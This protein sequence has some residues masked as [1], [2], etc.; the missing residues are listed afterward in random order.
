MCPAILIYGDTER[1]PTLRHEVPLAIGD[2][3][4]FIQED[5]PPTIMTNSL[6][7]SRIERALPGARL[8]LMEE[9]G[10]RDLIKDGMPREDATLEVISRAVDRAGITAASVP[11]EFP[12]AVADRLRA[13]GVEL[14]VDA[15]LFQ[16]RRRVKSEPELAGIRR[17]QR[18]ANAAMAAAETLL[19]SAD[20]VDGRLVVDGQPLTAEMVRAEIRETC[21]EYGAPAPPDVMVT[22]VLSGGGHDPGS[23]PLP[24]DLPITI[25]L[26]P[27]DEATSCS[28]DMTR[29][30]VVGA[31][32][33][34]VADLR[35]VV[36]D[37]LEAVRA[38][39]RPGV[40]GKELYDI[41]ASVIEAAGFPTQRTAAPGE[42]LSHG[43]YFSLGHGIGLEVHEGPGLGLSGTEE[44]VPGDVIAVEPGVEGVDGIGGVRYEDLLLITADGAETLTD[45]PYDL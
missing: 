14:T 31:I 26:W 44:L 17:A 13:D 12:L 34:E 39:A 9:L 30:F 40:T 24:A 37:A 25:D 4:L 43:F 36:R 33:D 10:I 1:S 27:R 23:G 8:L 2:P 35:D 18:A 19:R 20:R 22:S 16:N 28:A 15:R 6:E 38:A 41:A 32:P 5:G 21:A 29:T 7:K 3:F 11:P 42:V 45:Y